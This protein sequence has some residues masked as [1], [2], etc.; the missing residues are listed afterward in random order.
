MG[1]FY[2][3]SEDQRIN[4]TRKAIQERRTMIERW[5]ALTDEEATSWDER[6]AWAAQWLA[7]C[8]VV[9]DLGCG[10]MLLERRLTSA[11]YIP[12]DVVRRD[13]RTIVVDLNVTP[14]PPLAADG[15]AA[16]GLIEYLFDPSALLEAVRGQLVVSYNPTDLCSDERMAHAWVNA[17]DTLTM[18]SMI[19]E[20]GWVIE[21]TTIIGTQRLWVLRR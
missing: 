11:A 20:A 21:S 2:N 7:G 19:T 8:R 5:A 16:L 6:A 1:G 15:Y 3:L 13:A 18:Q 9:A 10:S 12:V 17:Y 4:L 14:L